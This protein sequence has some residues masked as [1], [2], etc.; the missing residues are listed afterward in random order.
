MTDRGFIVSACWH[1]LMLPAFVCLL[2]V[3]RVKKDP[4]NIIT[5]TK[6]GSLFQWAE[7]GFV[8]VATIQIKITQGRASPRIGRSHRSE[9][10]Q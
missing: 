3:T 5:L 1:I 4:P 9:F 7:E 10:L 2:F 8:P 6:V